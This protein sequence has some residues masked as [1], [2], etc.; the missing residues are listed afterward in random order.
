MR[1]PSKLSVAR[2]RHASQRGT[3]LIF[4]LVAL[5]GLSVAGAAMMR[6]SDTATLVSGSLGF[7]ES[8]TKSTERAV[9]AGIA[10]VTGMSTA[11]RQT[12]APANNYYA[13]LEA[14]NLEPTAARLSP[15]TDQEILDTQ[16]GNT[17][18]Y[19]VERMC[20]SGTG[21]PAAATCVMDGALPLYRVT[22]LGIGPRFSS[23]T[24]QAMFTI[25]VP[26]PTCGI[27]TQG[28][29]KVSG[30]SWQYGAS[31]C[32]HSNTSIDISGAARTG[33][34]TAS[35]VGSVAYG[36]GGMSVT[37]QTVA[38]SK[39][40]PTVDPSAHKTYARQVFKADGTITGT[41]FGA[42]LW[43]WDSGNQTWTLSASGTLPAA[44]LYYFE[45]NAEISGTLGTV[46]APVTI[47]IVA[48]KS[49]KIS[50]QVHLRDFVD[51]T[52]PHPAATNQVFLMAGG[53][54]ELPGGSQYLDTSR[55]A[56]VAA[57]AELKVNGSIEVEASLIAHNQAAPSGSQDWASENMV[58]GTLTQ[59]YDGNGSSTTPTASRQRW[60]LVTR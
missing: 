1:H 13:T 17:V 58:S 49:I 21:A 45:T 42:G 40:L 9:E 53:D 44:G 23:E 41:G 10:G 55:S 16:T 19:V 25:S 15:S 32:Y 34:L 35:A 54:I 48:E 20:A 3:S 8:V 37:T 2:G 18:R 29:L 51:L 38:P 6:S 4:S 27:V 43:S 30:E 11:S 52:T 50:A 31:N 60:R 36:G 14:V 39:A 7:Q 5:A 47:S 57:G 46:A 33:G 12:D 59:R 22:A 56:M 24:T 26:T 28:A